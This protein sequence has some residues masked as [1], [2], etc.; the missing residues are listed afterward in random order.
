MIVY[1]GSS[2]EV[3]RPDIY[4]SRDNVDF[5]KGFYITPIEEQAHKWAARF[6]RHQGHGILSVYEFDVDACKSCG[7]V[8]E[9]GGYTEEWL[10]FITTC[11]RMENKSEY[12]IVIGGV[13][14]DKVFNTIELYFEGLI[15]KEE[16]IKRLRYEKPNLQICIRN[17]ELIEKYLHFLKSEEI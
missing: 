8:L 9:F 10:D 5:G 13:A 6:K 7:K 3:N 2:I 1:H 4:H 12:D 15:A 14:N 16:A 17:Q 11:R